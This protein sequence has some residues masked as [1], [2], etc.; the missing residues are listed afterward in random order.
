MP[1]QTPLAMA[2]P[3]LARAEGYHQM[4]SQQ[5]SLTSFLKSPDSSPEEELPPYSTTNDARTPGDIYSGFVTEQFP[6]LL[7]PP[8]A[9]PSVIV[10]TSS[11][12][13]RPSRLSYMAPKPDE[14]PVLTLGVHA[15]S[16][17]KQL[18]RVEKTLGAM[19]VLDSQI[20][21]VSAF[22]DRLPDKTMFTGHAPAKI[23]ARRTAIDSYLENLLECVLDERAAMVMCTFLS[24]DAIGADGTGDYFPPATITETRPDTPVVTARPQRAGY[25][26]K[27][28]KNFGGWKARYFVLDGPNLR[29]FEGPGGA[30]LGSIKL[31]NAQIGKQSTNTPQN[32]QEDEDNQFRH[33]FLILE[34]KKKDSSSL[35]RHVLCAESDEERDAWVE[36]LLHYV[37]MKDDDDNTLKA[38]SAGIKPDISGS[39]SPRL[40]RSLNNLKASS[41]KDAFQKEDP[42]RSVGY[43][44]V[45]SGDAPV[46]G[47]PP[48]ADSPSPIHDGS[49]TSSHDRTSSSNHPVISGPT[50][51]TVI[52]NAG[53]WGMR[54]P[55]TPLTKE[56]KDKKRSMFSAFRGRA[57]SDLATGDKSVTSPGLPPSDYNSASG[58]RAVFGVPLIEAVEVSRPAGVTTELPAVVYRCIEYLTVKNA[59][60]EEGIFRLSGSN[61]II[62]SLKDRFN[63]EGDIDLVADETY[64]DIHAV[65]SLLKMYLREL[66]ASILT[67]ELHLEFLQCLEAHGHEKIAA[68]NVLVNRLPK[69]N[70]A[71]LEALS[72]F[73]TLR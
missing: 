43:S 26:T 49:S 39:R 36:A 15:R 65:A 5:N 47:G 46:F 14:N 69:P 58:V 13:M 3:H 60:S 31:Q 38:P 2:S 10:K 21:S 8:N 23:D 70:R 24:A 41:S 48:K 11:S 16:D 1:P 55:M 57:S 56:P 44:D 28:G 37:D 66:P 50:N 22:R 72:A 64:Y 12:R 59:I 30:H 62:K 71:L 25:L 29:Y 51:L 17:N 35:V 52:S 33:A 6:G 20:K 27:R 42:F 32:Q 7:L 19:S 18:W 9:L 45:A 40:Q 67:R 63:T 53:D 68:L 34:P 73:S 54:Q 4:H 61:T